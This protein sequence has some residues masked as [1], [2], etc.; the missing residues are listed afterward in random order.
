M[1]LLKKVFMIV[2]ILIYI[3]SIFFFIYHIYKLKTEERTNS[4]L[5][6][7][8]LLYQMIFSIGLTSLLSFFALMFY[9]DF[10]AEY[11]GWPSSPFAQELANVNLGYAVLGLL[12][13]WYRGSFW[14]ATIIGFSIWVVGDGFLHLYEL[15]FHDNTAPGNA[16]ILLYTDFIVPIILLISLYFYLRSNPDNEK[17]NPTI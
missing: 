11:S 14:I 13:I 1:Q 3:L 15:F 6:E 8:F 9:G 4:R 10:V 16:G 12:G 2:M 7:L 5:I 17:Q